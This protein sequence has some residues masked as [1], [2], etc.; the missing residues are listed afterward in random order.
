[1][2]AVLAPLVVGLAFCIVVRI[3]V[4]TKAVVLGAGAPGAQGA[5][6]HVIA[7]FPQDSGQSKD[8]GSGGDVRR[9]DVLRVALPGEVDRT[10]MGL[11]W[12]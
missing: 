12:G 2:Y 9:D 1:M 11:R 6:L 5:G 4:N 7:L 10:P 8:T 3:P